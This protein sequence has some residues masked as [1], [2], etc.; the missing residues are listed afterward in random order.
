[1]SV[2]GSIEA[3]AATEPAMSTTRPTEVQKMIW[4]I[5]VS[6]LAAGFAVRSVGSGRA[7]REDGVD[8]GVGGRVKVNGDGDADGDE[9]VDDGGEGQLLQNWLKAT[10][11]TVRG[12]PV[13]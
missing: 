8:G 6:M 7:K 12:I 9:D 11:L 5:S 2:V 4:N 3:S 13:A 1:M 10:R